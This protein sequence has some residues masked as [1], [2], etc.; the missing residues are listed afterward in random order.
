MAAGITLFLGYEIGEDGHWR[1]TKTSRR[2]PTLTTAAFHVAACDFQLYGVVATRLGYGSREIP[3]A[4]GHHT[5]MIAWWRPGES[6]G[7]HHASFDPRAKASTQHLMGPDFGR[8]CWVQFL[9]VE[10]STAEVLRQIDV[11]MPHVGGPQQ[12]PDFPAPRGQV[13]P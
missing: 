2:L 3:A 13:R 12:M 9:M 5:G 10:I 6:I 11:H 4:R 1:M 7:Y 8:V